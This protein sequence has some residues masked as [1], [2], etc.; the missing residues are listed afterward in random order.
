MDDPDAPKDRNS[1]GEEKRKLINSYMQEDFTPEDL[2]A[3]FM[4]GLSRSTVIKEGAVPCR[5]SY[6]LKGEGR[7][8]CS[9][10]DQ[11]CFGLKG[12]GTKIDHCELYNGFREHRGKLGYY[13]YL[14]RELGEKGVDVSEFE[15]R[16]EEVRDY[17]LCKDLTRASAELKDLHGRI[18]LKRDELE[19]KLSKNPALS[20]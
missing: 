14:I 10:V 11:D 20:S 7:F 6:S 4:K 5:H 3:E 8:A 18:F 1:A 16:L 17:L 9:G 2:V 15:R 13:R 19:R 12:A